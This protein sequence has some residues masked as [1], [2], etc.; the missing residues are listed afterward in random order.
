MFFV[1]LKNKLLDY[2]LLEHTNAMG[3]VLK[4]GDLALVHFC[5]LKTSLP[6]SKP[7]MRLLFSEIF[8]ISG[9]TPNSRTLFV[10]AK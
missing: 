4:L 7:A 3:V 1:L 6:S 9:F 10:A 8:W 5:P 2:V